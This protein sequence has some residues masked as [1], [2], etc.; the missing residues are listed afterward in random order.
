MATTDKVLDVTTRSKTGTTSSHA[1]RKSGRVP[2]IIFGHGSAPAAVALDA[3]AFDALLHDGGKNALLT[4]TIDGTGRDTAVVRDVQRDPLTRRVLHVDLQRVGA[5]EEITASLPIV[6]VGTP[7]GVRNSG[8]VLDVILHAMDVKG[9]ANALPETIEIPVEHLVIHDKVTA[10]DVKLPPNLS[11]DMDPH[12]I[13][14]G[15]EPSTVAQ[16]AAE[17][18]VAEAPAA[19]TEP[20]VAGAEPA[21]PA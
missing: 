3:K 16:Q 8:G 17:D 5:T 10:G 18:E 13:L 11:L 12:T 4:V 15:I 21:E 20:E 7:D 6:T 14:L 19:P 2:G 9:P 1:V